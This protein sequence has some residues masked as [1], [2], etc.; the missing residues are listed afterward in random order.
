[1]TPP[2]PT[3]WLHILPDIVGGA[4][5]ERGN[6]DARV[7]RARHV[8]HRHVDGDALDLG[9]HVEAGLVGQVVIEGD[10]IERLGGQQR[11][12]F[13]PGGDMPDADAVR[14][15]RALHQPAD[16]RIV[17]DVEDPDLIHLQSVAGTCITERKRPSCWIALAKLS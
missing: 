12:P 6:R 14:R 10:G 17:V 8:D 2:A 7:L 4:G 3:S 13:V 11:E 5:L 16:T 1:M 15:E 9:Q